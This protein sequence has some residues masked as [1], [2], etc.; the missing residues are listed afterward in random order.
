MPAN[1][2]SLTC[3]WRS[4]GINSVVII[5]SPLHLPSRCRTFLL[6]Q[7]AQFSAC[8]LD[9]GQGDAGEQ[10]RVRLALE[11]RNGSFGVAVLGPLHALPGEGEGVRVYGVGC[12][13]YMRISSVSQ[14][15]HVR[16]I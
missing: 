12:H 15:S 4:I 8:S 13:A 11:H 6:M 1:E 2:K 7:P 3:D 16:E 5:Q 10:W 14:K 9:F